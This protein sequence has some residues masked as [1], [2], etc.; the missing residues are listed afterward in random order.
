MSNTLLLSSLSIVIPTFNRG[1]VLLETIGFLQELQPIPL[2]ILIID[3]TQNHEPGIAQALN[4]LDQTQ[5]IR[6]IRLPRPS[7]PK[8][9]NTGLQLA[10]GDIVL[11]LDDDIIPDPNLIQGHLHAHQQAN[12]VVG[13]VIQPNE[14][15]L[16]LQPG[17][18]FRFNSTEPCFIQDCMAGN[19]SIKT[20][21]A[22]QLGGFDENFQGAAFKFESEFAHRYTQQYGPIYFEPTASIHHL[23]AQRGGT[24]AHGH[25]LRTAKPTHSLGVYYYLM[26]SRPP[27]WLLQLLNRPIKAIHTKHHLRHPWWIP[28]SLWA[29]LVGFLWA[30]KCLAQGPRYLAPPASPASASL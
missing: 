3:Q 20:T 19:L 10:Q 5:K 30:L 9:M 29:E 14:H 22:R 1:E 11:F 18:S 12:L 7:I 13:Q 4:T 23:M 8:A 24:R 25:H 26:K 16:P 27:H 6:W 2:E 17:E 15:P 21:I 28:L